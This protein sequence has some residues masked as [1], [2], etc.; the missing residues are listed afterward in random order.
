MI[1]KADVESIAEQVVIRIVTDPQFSSNY[2][3]QARKYQED[4][5][6]LEKIEQ[7]LARQGYDVTID[8]IEDAKINLQKTSLLMRCGKLT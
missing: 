5:D 2:A 3:A 1:M 8:D 4:P 6:G 7:W